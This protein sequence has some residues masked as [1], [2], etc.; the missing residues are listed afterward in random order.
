MNDSHDRHRVVGFDILVNDV[1]GRH[2]ADTDK[3]T[4]R[5]EPLPGN[6]SKRR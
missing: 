6:L 2:N 4:E 5:R 1:G 3:P